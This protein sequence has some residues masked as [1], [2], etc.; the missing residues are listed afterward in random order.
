M[1]RPVNKAEQ[2][3]N[4]IARAKCAEEWQKPLLK[5]VWDMKSVRAKHEVIN[6][7]RKCGFKAHFGR[8]FMICVEK[9]S[10]L[11][12]GSPDRKFK[13]RCVF[14][15]NNVKDEQRDWAIFNDL[16]VLSSSI[17]MVYNPDM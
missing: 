16:G 13:G 11:C 12:I 14:Q 3:R 7:A 15:G 8:L 6:E 5:E 2:S 10:E 4:P 17:S 1:A 9:G